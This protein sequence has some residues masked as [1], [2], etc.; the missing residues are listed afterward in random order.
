MPYLVPLVIRCEEGRASDAPRYDG[1][2][3]RRTQ[4]AYPIRVSGALQGLMARI[5]NLLIRDTGDISRVVSAQPE[6]AG[7]RL[8]S[9]DELWRGQDR[10]DLP[11]SETRWRLD[12]RGGPGPWA[13][14]SSVYR[15]DE[16]ELRLQNAHLTPD[17]ERTLQLP[18]SVNEVQVMRT[19]DPLP[20]RDGEGLVVFKPSSGEEFG[21]KNWLPH[22]PG[23]LARREV[24]AYRMDRLFGFGL[25]P[26]TA[27]V[28]T[29]GREGMVQQFVDFG[30]MTWVNGFDD[31]QR[32]RAAV[33][34]YV[35]GAGDGRRGNYRPDR[36]GNLVL[37]D[38]GYSF[39]EPAHPTRG[40]DE[41]GPGTDFVLRSDFVTF[42]PKTQLDD[43]VL[44]AVD[45]ID[46]R[47]IRSALA[48][49]DLD[50]RAIDGVLQRLNEIR[51]LRAIP[52]I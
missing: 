9:A 10:P 19:R 34:H 17:V 30:P 29:Q 5:K 24:A 33:L 44:R 52:G 16:A 2:C 6:G 27:L 13:R 36:N 1:P 22:T 3:S 15:P 47:D 42:D 18:D 7:R 46:H 28:N 38:H 40:A 11:A 49:L 51:E 20:G 25:V 50:P 21:K 41:L 23:A 14:R 8:V 31:A 4:K 45:A 39:P 12:D 37:Y 32:Q 26:P 48:D 43:D 35:I